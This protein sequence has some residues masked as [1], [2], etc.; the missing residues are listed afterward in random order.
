MRRVAGARDAAPGVP[1][2]LTGEGVGAPVCESL[3]EDA[4]ARIR[5][6]VALARATGK[7]VTAEIA[8]VTPTAIR[9]DE[10]RLVPR[11]GG[12]LLLIA[13]D[14]TESRRAAEAL[15]QSEEKYRTLY[16]RTP[17]MLHSI[18]AAGRLLSVSDRWLQRL[19]YTADEVLGHA[20]TDFL[21]EESQPLRARGGVSLAFFATGSLDDVPLQFV[22]RDGSVV[23]VLLSATS[24]RDSADSI[25]RS[26]SVL[27]DVTEQRRATRELAE[28]DRTM[29]TLL[30]N[31]PGMAYRC[32]NDRRLEHAA[33]ERRL[34]RPDRATTPTS[35]RR[36]G[37]R[38]TATSSSPPTGSSSGTPS[39]PRCASTE[40]WTI[41]Y[42]IVSSDGVSKSV[43]ERGIGV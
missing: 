12:T 27:V 1:G 32:A 31:I 40:P 17:V 14:I 16:L 22:A 23:D 8:T 13:R 19:G 35:C 43:W 5:K 6:A 15:R 9:Y 38:P 2:V 24:E 25:I 18:D 11:E 4:S 42:R 41:T 30:A 39:R 33:P 7:P 20:V 29:Q 21:T 10:V 36:R 37:T 34:P 3:S 26:L 28:R